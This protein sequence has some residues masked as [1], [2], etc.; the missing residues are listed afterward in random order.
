LLFLTSPHVHIAFATDYGSIGNFAFFRGVQL[1]QKSMSRAGK[2][3][4]EYI[5]LGTGKI[6]GT[7]YYSRSK[8][9]ES[10]DISTVSSTYLLDYMI[11]ELFPIGV[12]LE[13]ASVL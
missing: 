7:R 4:C 12:V 11:V 9:S 5:C 2:S 8:T 13:Q 10:L 1:E 6:K 3:C